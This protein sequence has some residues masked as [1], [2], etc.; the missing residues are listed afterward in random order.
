MTCVS[1][2][3]NPSRHP[4]SISPS[5]PWARG[6]ER[7]VKGGG[8]SAFLS[9]PGSWFSRWYKTSHDTTISSLTC[10]N[11]IIPSCKPATANPSPFIQ[12]HLNSRRIN[13]CVSRRIFL[14]MIPVPHILSLAGRA[15]FPGPPLRRGTPQSCMGVSSAALLE[16]RN[17]PVKTQDPKGNVEWTW[18][19]KHD[20]AL[21]TTTNTDIRN[22]SRWKD[23][24]R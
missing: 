20:D 14:S 5:Q 17:R 11:H 21:T 3:L 8:A 16:F 19:E 9:V 24:V 2:L 13:G 12:W 15:A 6:R 4:I 23:D 10:I 1:Y 7:R 18:G 22:S